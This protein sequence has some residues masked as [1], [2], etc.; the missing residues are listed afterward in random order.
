L[1]KTFCLAPWIHAFQA[2][3][4]ERRLCCHAQEFTKESITWS[5]ESSFE[6]YWNSEAL[7]KI[8]LLM[9]KGLAPT[10][11]CHACLHKEATL[12]PPYETYNFARDKED[13]LLAQT[14]EVGEL[15]ALPLS[16]DYRIRNQCNLSCR[17]CNSLY[18]SK[19]EAKTKEL[20]LLNQSFDQSAAQRATQE[21]RKIVK[22]SS[23]ELAYFA[24]GE[25]FIQSDH[26]EDLR[27][28]KEE[29]DPKKIVLN[30]NTNL[31]FPLERI[32]KEEQ[33]LRS[34]KSVNLAVSIDGYGESGEF[35]RDGLSWHRF[36]QNIQKIRESD[37]LNLVQ[38]DITLTLPTLL[39]LEPLVAFLQEQRIKYNVT[40]IIPGGYATL[41]SPLLLKREDLGLLL[42]E[43]LSFLK[44]CDD[45]FLGPL[46]SFLSEMKLNLPATSPFTCAELK[47]SLKLAKEMD[48]NFKRLPLLTYY[49]NFSMVHEVLEQIAQAIQ[50]EHRS[51]VDRETLYWEELLKDYG[52]H[53]RNTF[54]HTG[55]TEVPKESSVIV[56]SYPS[57][58]NKLLSSD[59]EKFKTYSLLKDYPCKVL[60]PFSYLCRNHKIL[61][62]FAT[63]LDG[64]TRPVRRLLAFHV[65]I[66]V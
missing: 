44:G 48:Q 50:E 3:N 13:E 15:K 55:L 4:G 54:I 18:S 29:N 34:F 12:M 30:Y 58:L 42:D 63:F 16:L 8:R 22:E 57:L 61:N 64:I 46:I 65:I 47:T 28:L 43:K 5:Q 23:I 11:E 1:S 35:I 10:H 56:A 49:Q 41:I 53:E 40:Q 60:G 17:T 19:I 59:Q 38:F 20:N 45:D 32:F 7:K 33:L 52:Y 39:E 24:G 2:P 14:S 31:A 6:E 27:I 9:I 62:L 37:F 51:H 21:W 66:K 25:A 26:F 36:Y